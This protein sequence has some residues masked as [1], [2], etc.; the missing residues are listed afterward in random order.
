MN[1]ILKIIL[2]V[3]VLLSAIGYGGYRYMIHK[4]K[5]FS[6]EQTVDYEKASYD[7][8]VFYN[9]PYKKGREIFGSLGPFNKVW[10][11]GVNEA[12]TFKT[13]SVNY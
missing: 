13:H 6:P 3:A 12:T 1:K 4:T 10:R 8:E 5:A 11:T 2:I 9:R 7:L